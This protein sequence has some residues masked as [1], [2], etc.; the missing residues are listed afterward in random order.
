MTRT[1]PIILDRLGASLESHGVR[2]KRA[3]LLETAAMAFGYHN[4][5]EFTAA[6]R[7]GE[8]DAPRPVVIGRVALEETT[9]I[10]LRDISGG[11]YAIEESFIE[12][13]VEDERREHFG[14]SP[15]GGLVDLRDVADDPAT[16]FDATTR[17]AFTQGRYRAFDADLGLIA[18]TNDLEAAR[19]ACR[20]GE[21]DNLSSYIVDREAK[22]ISY[23]R[24]CWRVEDLPAEDDPTTMAILLH[25]E[26]RRADDLQQRYETTLRLDVPD[27]RAWEKD[28]KVASRKGQEPISDEILHRFRHAVADVTSKSSAS[29]KSQVTYRQSRYLEKHLGGLIARLDRAEEAL[30]EAGLAPAEIARKS[31][32]DAA[33]RLA[34]IEAVRPRNAGRHIPNL[35][36]VNA[37]RDGETCSA[38]YT[39]D[40]YEHWEDKGREIVAK[41]FGMDLEEWRD[42]D[43]ELWMFDSECDTFE[44]SEV[45]YPD[46]AAII[47]DALVE[48]ST[49]GDFRFGIPHDHPARIKLI[50]ARDMLVPKPTV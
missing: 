27:W 2:L 8:L 39:V 47:S 12:K 40:Q 30:R 20:D 7:S 32:D 42:E 33:E 15:Y 44:V 43:G 48:L 1:A 24:M 5:N 38:Y 6:A 18:E 41:E 50:A 3:Q 34:A 21:R 35:Y 16:M 29:E 36:K 19:A 31:K 10:A 25:L 13:V 9:L 26:L 45:A 49:G 28:L 4:Q 22:T 14:P 11:V 17:P 46:A 23:A 37:T